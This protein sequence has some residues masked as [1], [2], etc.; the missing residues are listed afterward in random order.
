MQ[1][2][3]KSKNTFFGDKNERFGGQYVPEI[4]Y[5][6]LKELENAYKNIFHTKEFQAELKELMTHFVNRPT[7]LIYAKNASEILQN[8]IY[9]KFEGLANTGAHKINNAIGQVLLA[10]KMG[11][12]RIIAETG[13][14]QHGLAT[15]CACAKLGLEC[16]I[17]MGSVDIARQRPNVLNM[18]LFGA[19][20]RSIDSGTKTLKDA[21]NEALREWSK[22]SI[23]TFYVLGS[24]LGPYPY[25]DIVRDLQSI[26]SK[27]VLSQIKHYFTGMPDY[28]I[29]CVGGGSNAIGFFHAFLQKDVKLIGVEAGGKGNNSGEHAMRMQNSK[30]AQ[31]GI[32]QGYKTIFLQ[33]QEGQLAKTHSIS[34]GLDYA[35]IGPQ[36]AHLGKIGRIQFQSAT[37]DEVLEALKFFAKTEGIIAALES[38]H[39][40][41]GAIKLCQTQKNKKIIINISGRGDK[42]IFITAKYLKTNIWEDFLGEEIKRIQE[43]KAIK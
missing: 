38:S 11:K 32:A 13:A 1:L 5:P 8:D 6:A 25:P 31:T 16:E 29:A 23:N 15:A 3:T 36:L 19:K 33:N 30:D 35:G 7:P 43:L 9:L 27:E 10:K 42:D 39:A 26:I 22:D 12:T 2:Y 24:A 4:L 21:V 18:E 41:A 20:V 34:A 14:G 28:M 40:L 17:F 37:D